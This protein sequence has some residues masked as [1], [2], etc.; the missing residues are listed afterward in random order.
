MALEIVL[1]LNFRLYIIFLDFPNVFYAESLKLSM[2]IMSGL[3]LFEKLNGK[4]FGRDCG[5]KGTVEEML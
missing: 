2:S 1:N 5:F 3:S 4:L